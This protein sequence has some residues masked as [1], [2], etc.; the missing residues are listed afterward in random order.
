MSATQRAP[1]ALTNRQ[2]TPAMS[3]IAISR[4]RSMAANVS[5]FNTVFTYDM[6]Q[7]WIQPG[8]EDGGNQDQ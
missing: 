6:W 3:G 2:T 4:V 8:R 1:F 5:S 7:D